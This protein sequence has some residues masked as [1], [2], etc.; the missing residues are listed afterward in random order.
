MDN[1]LVLYGVI[2]MELFDL[3]DRMEPREKR[4][5]EPNVKRDRKSVEAFIAHLVAL[6]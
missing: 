5:R 1:D 4:K 3:F 6:T 2:A